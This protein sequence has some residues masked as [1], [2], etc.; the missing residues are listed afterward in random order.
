MASNNII[1]SITSAMDSKIN[2]LKSIPSSL[3]SKVQSAGSAIS[4]RLN[5]LFSDIMKKPSE[6]KDYVKVGKIYISKKTF[7]IGIL[8]IIVVVLLFV[9][10][11]Y[12]WADGNL[13]TANVKINSQKYH[14]F[15]GKKVRVK[16]QMGVVI[17]KG[18]M[19]NGTITGKGTQYDS[20]GKLV[21][22]GEFENG[23]YSNQGKLY[24]S[25]KVLIYN[26][27]FSQNLYQGE[28][29]LYN[30]TG[31]L[32][33]KGNFDAGLR[34]GTGVEYSPTTGKKIYYGSFANDAREGK[35]TAF[36]DD[37]QHKLY[38]GDFVAGEYSGSGKLYEN[39]ILK[40]VGAFENGFYSGEGTLYDIETSKVLYKGAF[41][42]GLYEGDGELYDPKTSKLVYKGAFVAGKKSGEGSTFDRLGSISFNGEFKDDNVNY[43]N[44]IGFPLEEISGQFGKE[45]YRDTTNDGKLILTYLSLDMSIVFKSDEDE[46]KY[47]CEKMITG[48]KGTF[49]GLKSTSSKE[50]I[51]NV[52]GN[53]YSS[54]EYSFAKYYDTVFKKLSIDLN[55]STKAPS[56]KFLMDGYYVRF[57]YNKNRTEYLAVE[58]SSL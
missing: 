34:S 14:S 58:I 30:N 45:S 52:M 40:Y 25:E 2:A 17:Y 33:Y 8:A 6:K 23:S 10:Y 56:D 36:T 9:K 12:P 53:P 21:Y 18:E 39:G 35:G 47:V 50:E 22:E 3:I 51:I 48:N 24:N 4:N 29:E 16:D 41:V 49:S 38:E 27:G 1:S 5:N 31:A 11:F 19:S 54:V 15:T 7:I 13:W 26:G 42:A 28:G 44:Y 37:G 46:G 20:D 57:Y 55:S 43:L 32:I